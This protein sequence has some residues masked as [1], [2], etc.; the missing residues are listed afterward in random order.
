MFIALQ[1]GK[2]P[3]LDIDYRGAKAIIDSGLFPRENIV[4]IFIAADADELY[5]RLTYRGTETP[6][7][8]QKRLI[9]SLTESDVVNSG[10]Y[11]IVLLNHDLDKTKKQFLSIIQGKDCESQHFD[12]IEFQ[13]SIRDI[14]R[15]AAESDKTIIQYRI[16]VKDI[17]IG[18][19]QINAKGQHRYFPIK[20][21]VDK[22]Y[23][24]ITFGEMLHPRNWGDPIPFFEN[25]IQDARRFNVE[26]D[27]RHQTNPFHFL[28]I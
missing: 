28:M 3:V 23:N 20:E 19:L 9:A 14:F 17:E 21:N 10:L 18:L 22:V 11:D 1:N 15:K 25:R 26:R 13:R 24:W 7:T 12:E 8:I 5:S 6:A 4:S 27:F 16:F 2:T